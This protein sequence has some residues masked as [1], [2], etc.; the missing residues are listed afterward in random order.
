MVCLRLEGNLFII[1]IKT[2]ILFRFVVSGR[3]VVSPTL[4]R[5]RDTPIDRK[6]ILQT[7]TLNFSRLSIFDFI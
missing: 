2:N 3:V 7:G 6:T 1:V 5:Y 4:S